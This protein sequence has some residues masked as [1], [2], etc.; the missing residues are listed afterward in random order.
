MTAPHNVPTMR[1]PC[2][3][4]DGD[5]VLATVEVPAS[6]GEAFRA[7]TTEELEGWWRFP[8]LYDM[9]TWTADL[10]VGGRWSV[11]MRA[12]VGAIFPISGKI[13]AIDA[14]REIVL[15]RKREWNDPELGSHETTV[16]YRLDP[17][18]AGARI[19]VRQEHFADFSDAAE[20]SADEWRRVLRAL[21]DYMKSKHDLRQGG[22]VSRGGKASS[23][24]YLARQFG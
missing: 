18:S 3:V 4:T 6:L 17:T 24:L 14:P 1:S 12:A 13:L 23:K 8:D 9:A 19:T 15:T 10:R 5:T 21:S 11:K 7:L 16:T 22:F 2:A 20:Q